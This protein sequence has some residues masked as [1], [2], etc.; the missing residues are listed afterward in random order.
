M[1]ETEKV[2]MIW[3]CVKGDRVWTAEVGGGNGS[4][5]E[6]ERPEDQEK[7]GEMQSGRISRY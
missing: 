5:G 6:K 3:S 2:T 1:N 4:A 7:L